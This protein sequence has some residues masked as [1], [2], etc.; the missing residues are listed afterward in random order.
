M[1]QSKLYTPRNF[2]AWGI[3]IARRIIFLNHSAK[4]LS[5]P[6]ITHGEEA[7]DY[8]EFYIVP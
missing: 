1:D 8:I 3:I 7:L 5:S 2:V 6:F 4:F